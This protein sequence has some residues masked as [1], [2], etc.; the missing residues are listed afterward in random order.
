MPMKNRNVS[1]PKAASIAFLLLVS[2]L[3][4]P[5]QSD[6]SR[7]GQWRMAGQN[8]SN[9]WSQPAEHSISPA[10]VNGLTPKWVFTTGGDVSATPTVDG[11]A[12]YFPDWGGNLF[13]VEKD[14]GR[15]IWSRKISEYDGVEGAI[16]RVSPAVGGNQVITGDILN[17]KQ[18][19]N[20]AN[21]ISVDRETGTIQWMTQVDTHPAAIITGSPLVFD[22][23]VYFGISSSEDSTLYW[24]SGYRNVP[25]GIGNNKVYAFTLAGAKD[26]SEHSNDRD[27]SDDHGEPK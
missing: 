13:A 26:R 27:R 3:S 2:A 24:G 6:E 1:L 19:H 16:S 8:L 9:S 12:V 15:L 10:N 23:T 22:G 18:V 5:G 21:V 20:G 25:P 7:S 14:S 11:N 17:S 4:A